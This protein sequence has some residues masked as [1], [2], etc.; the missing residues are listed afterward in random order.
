MSATRYAAFRE[1]LD[2]ALPTLSHRMR[3]AVCAAAADRGFALFYWHTPLPLNL[4]ERALEV[5]WAFALG[6]AVSLDVSKPLAQDLDD[7][8][9]DRADDLLLPELNVANA[10][11]TAVAAVDPNADRSSP[12]WAL[13]WL[14][15]CDDADG[16]LEFAWAEHVIAQASTTRDDAITRDLFTMPPPLRL[17]RDIGEHSPDA[18]MIAEASQH[19]ADRQLRVDAWRAS[20]S[21][22]PW[23][24]PSGIPQRYEVKTVA[25]GASSTQGIIATSGHHLVAL[26]ERGSDVARFTPNAAVALGMSADERTLFAWRVEKRA[27][28]SG[29]GRDDYDWILDQYDWPSAAL[30][31]SHVL[32]SRKTIA[33][34]W[35]IRLD[36][37]VTEARA[38]VIFRA[39]SEDFTASVH[40]VI[41]E[42]E[43]RETDALEEAQRWLAD[44]R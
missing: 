6:S 32:T 30:R 23:R 24:E 42:A 34:C 20:E 16:E 9:S 43:I 28:Q 13:N 17:V 39:R 4:L 38:L 14:L 22:P 37:P 21:A 35:P 36:V 26:F 12:R 41:G 5:A 31:T 8:I 15:D 27:G 7:A 33:W 10:T 19:A 40:V 18:D 1:Q 29:V 25:R 3:V 2:A 44:I 11:Q